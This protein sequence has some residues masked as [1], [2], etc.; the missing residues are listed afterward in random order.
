[1]IN[2]TY[3]LYNKFLKKL[4]FCDIIKL[5]LKYGLKS[6]TEYKVNDETYLSDKLPTSNTGENF[7]TA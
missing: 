4:P 1:M 7:N 2:L 6:Y 5:L 3:F